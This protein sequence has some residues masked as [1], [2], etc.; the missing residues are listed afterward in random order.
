MRPFEP[1]WND[2]VRRWAEIRR[3]LG[4]LTRLPLGTFA[5]SEEMPLAQASWAFP[6]TGIVIGLLGGIA[7]AIAALIGLPANAAALAA[8]AA[9]ALVTGALHEDGLADTADGFGGGATRADKLEIM[10][11]SRIGAYG[12]LALIFSIGLRWSAL[13]ALAASGRVMAALIAA[14]AVSRGLLPL[15][16]RG[17]EPARADGLGATAGRP[18]PALAWSAAGIAAIVS[19]FALDFLPGIAALIAAAIVVALIA[20]IARRQIGGY[21][22]DTLGAI[23]QGG[24][25]A[26][27]LAAAA[28]SS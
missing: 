27:L 24:E 12:V 3:A 25:I 15:V 1:G 19:I 23:E 26:M 17:F 21:T 28:W 13:A 4:F 5:E 22:G 2:A 16:L 8:L 10:R 18:D 9:A 14:H 7:Y 20:A 11:D 6:L